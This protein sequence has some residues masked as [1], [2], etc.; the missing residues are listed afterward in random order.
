MPVAMVAPADV[1]GCAPAVAVS[2][3][4]SAAATL[5]PWP[6]SH[7]LFR[8][9]PL[10]HWSFLSLRRARHVVPRLVDVVGLGGSLMVP[11]VRGVPAG[12]FA[13]GSDSLLAS[14]VPPDPAAT[15]SGA[16]LVVARL[17]IRRRSQPRWLLHPL[18]HPARSGRA[19][20]HALGSLVL[21]LW[22][23]VP[24]SGSCVV[25]AGGGCVDTGGA[26]GA[27]PSGFVFSR[28]WSLR[29]AML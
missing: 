20:R 4:F 22:L 29:A 25:F 9:Q 2:A 15:T 10:H 16:G 27:P 6:A 23:F 28:S 11:G 26:G 21:A 5:F 3:A 7:F 13:S 19:V 17:V 24:P 12:G 8:L 18:H 1:P 14:S